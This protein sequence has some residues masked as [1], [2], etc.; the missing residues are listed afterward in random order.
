MQT[1]ALKKLVFEHNNKTLKMS[2]LKKSI[3]QGNKYHI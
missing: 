2:F 1:E 3:L